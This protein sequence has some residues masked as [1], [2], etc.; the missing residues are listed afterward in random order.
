MALM[1]QIGEESISVSTTAIG[2]TA[3]EVTTNVVMARI[4]CETAAVRYNLRTT[5]QTPT[6]GGSEGS[7][8][9]YPDEEIEVWGQ[10]DILRFLAVSKDGATAT[11]RTQFFGSGG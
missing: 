1:V 11:L 7:P 6:A 5:T 3:A 10:T 9:L 2:V 4:R 8:I